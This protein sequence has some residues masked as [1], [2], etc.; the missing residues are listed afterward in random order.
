MFIHSIIPNFGQSSPDRE[1]VELL[2]ESYPE[3]TH[4]A[5]IQG[6]YSSRTSLLNNLRKIHPECDYQDL[7]LMDF[8]QL[9]TFPNLTLSL[10]HSP[11][12]GAS[13]VALKTHYQSLGIDIEPLNREVKE[14]IIQR[15]STEKDLKLE[16]RQMWCLKEA[17]YKCVANSKKYQGVL[18]FRDMEIKKEKWLHSPSS[19][20]GEW[21]LFIEENHQVAIATLKNQ[22][23]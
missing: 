7:K 20:S 21:K 11:L 14:T 23:S 12:A 17:I 19:L 5:R 18:E 1:L 2:E 6:F 15:V 22:N 13:V 4:P 8:H 3:A 9:Q 16:N 10:S